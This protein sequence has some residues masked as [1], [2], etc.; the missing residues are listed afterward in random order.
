MDF[1]IQEACRSEF[2]RDLGCCHKSSLS[3]PETGSCGFQDRDLPIAKGLVSAWVER[4][5]RGGFVEPGALVV[6]PALPAAYG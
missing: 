5:A 4:P 2:I 3:K 1:W 6:A